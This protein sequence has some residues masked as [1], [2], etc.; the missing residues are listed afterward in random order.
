MTQHIVNISGGKDSTACYL[1]A[2]E[3][4]RPFR[5]VMADTGHEHPMTV[6]YAMQLGA[7][8]GGP[9]V[10]IVRADFSRQME[11]KRRFIEASWADHGVDQAAIEAAIAILQPTGNP[12][13]DLCLWKGRFPS[14]MAQFCTEQLK[15]LPMDA[16]VVH[17]ALLAGPVVQW[18]GVRRDES[19]NR[20]D[21]PL[22]Q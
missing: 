9:E 5:A 13:L 12:F 8:T 14:R 11:G 10:E 1:L 20:R 15:R 7:R 18:L 17:P 22:F 6:E 3:R 21:A 19:L 4:G 2:M 16:Q